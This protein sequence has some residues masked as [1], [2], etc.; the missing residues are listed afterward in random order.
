MSA[1]EWTL[2]VSDMINTHTDTAIQ[3]FLPSLKAT[4]GLFVANE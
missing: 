1:A 3:K 2:A 4:S